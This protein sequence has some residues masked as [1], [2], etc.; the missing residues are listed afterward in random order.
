MKRAIVFRLLRITLLPLLIRET[1]QRRRITII[2]YHDPSPETLTTHLAA[3]RR[4]Y[5]LI[6]LRQFVEARERGRL[7]TLP[8]KSLVVTIDDGHAGNFK[9][10]PLLEELNVPVTI[11]L[12]SGIARAGR[13]FWFKHVPK[14]VES[15]KHMPDAERLK[16]LQAVGFDEAVETPQRDALSKD[17]IDELAPFVDFQSHTI[18]HPVLPHCSSEKASEEIFRSKEDLEREYGFYVYA[19]SYPNGDFSDRE[20]S[21]AKAAGYRCALTADVGFNSDRTD[22]FRLR[23]MC[24]DDNDDIDELLVKTSG[25]WAWIRGL[26][27]QKAFGYSPPARYH[28][29]PT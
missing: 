27:K 22:P 25:L 19:L 23:R 26:L 1:I 18:T 2:F 28:S 9:L 21:L 12:C 6:S 7:S 13:R 17:E 10:K 5:N 8:R 16:R 14:E 3:L 4:T 24:I 15:L 20:I 29:P 11:F